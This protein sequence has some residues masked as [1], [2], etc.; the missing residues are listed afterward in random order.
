MSKNIF[1]GQRSWLTRDLILTD[2][3]LSNHVYKRI[4]IPPASGGTD[5]S[6]TTNGHTNG[7]TNDHANAHANDRTNTHGRGCALGPAQI[8]GLGYTHPWTKTLDFSR[9]PPWTL[10][11]P[12]NRIQPQHQLSLANA[13]QGARAPAG[14]LEASNVHNSWAEHPVQTMSHPQNRPGPD[15][16]R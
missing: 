4:K 1:S 2:Y 7:H 15:L 3:G 10:P 11:H 12:Q 6:T 14:G 5:N 13:D 8:P 9:P 16:H